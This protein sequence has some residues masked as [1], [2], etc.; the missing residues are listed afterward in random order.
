[1]KLIN[2]APTHIK[3]YCVCDH[4]DKIFESI[5]NRFDDTNMSINKIKCTCGNDLFNVYTDPNPTVKVICT[6][7]LN[8]IIVYDLIYYPAATKC[9]QED[10]VFEMVTLNLQSELNVYAVYDY[11]DEY[12][13][14]NDVT[15]C[16]VYISFLDDVFELI[17]DE[18]A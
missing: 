13:D 6:E 12:E 8:E 16:Y 11:G 7:C 3:K 14:E 18:T 2:I 9:P 10:D 15:W 17:N 4:S 1:M 5:F